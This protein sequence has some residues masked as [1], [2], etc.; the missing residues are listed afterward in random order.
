[1]VPMIGSW[2]RIGT[3]AVVGLRRVVDEAGDGK[4]L[5]VAQLDFRFGSAHGERGDAETLEQDAVVEVER[6]D[7]RP[8]AQLDQIARNRRREVQAHAKFPELDSDGANAAREGH[9]KFAAGKEAGFLAVVS[10]Q[11]RFGQALEVAGLPQG[12]D[13]R[14]PC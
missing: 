12:P 2:L 6:A 11:I 5:A 1:M 4:R 9:R 7:L 14:C 3:A 10:E 13:E 8:Y